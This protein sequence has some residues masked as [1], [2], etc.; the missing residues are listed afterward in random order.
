ML[1]NMLHQIEITRYFNQ[2][3]FLPMTNL[4]KQL[5]EIPHFVRNDTPFF[6]KEAMEKVRL[7]RTFSIAFP[8]MNTCHF[9]WSLGGM[10]NLLFLS[11]NTF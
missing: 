11:Q 10:R 3:S 4:R 2:T 5:F 1:A 7:R 8:I 6:V 9:E